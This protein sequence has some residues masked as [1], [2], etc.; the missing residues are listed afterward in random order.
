MSEV[1]FTAQHVVKQYGKNFALNKFD[2]EIPRG[3]IYGF[4]GGNG[5]GKTTLMRILSGRIAQTSGKIEI[6]GKSDEKELCVQRGHIGALIEMPA[7]YSNMTARDNL[8]VLRLQQGLVEKACIM[9]ALE[10]VGLADAG[11]K[12]VKDFSLGMK[13][14]MGLAM[15]LMGNR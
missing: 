7:L 10:V 1:I 11:M 14:R 15:A 12:K 8:E 6:F 2:M 5:A 9:K 3:S 13:Q 4:V